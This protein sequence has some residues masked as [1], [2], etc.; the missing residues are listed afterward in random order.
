[1]IGMFKVCSQISDKKI[2]RLNHGDLSALT[3]A[4]KL[5][6]SLIA[7]VGG[8]YN[9]TPIMG[10]SLTTFCF[11]NSVISWAL[12][13]NKLHLTNLKQMVLWNNTVIL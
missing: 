13:R 8:L 1:M 7:R 4:D 10:D 5:V 9:Y 12:P 11:K 3:S 2:D 6:H